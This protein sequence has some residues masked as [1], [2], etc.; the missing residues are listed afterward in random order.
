MRLIKKL[1]FC[2]VTVI[3]A[4]ALAACSGGSSAAP[5]GAPPEVS[6]I[7]IDVIPT[8]DAAGIY[9]AADDGYFTQQGLNVKIVT[10]ETGA[11]Q[12]GALQTGAAQLVQGS[13]VGFIQ[14]Q[15]AGSFDG[16]PVS[17]RFVADTAEM[18]PGNQGLFVMP[19]HFDSLDQLIKAHATVGVSENDDVGALLLD[20]L[21]SASGDKEDGIK[22]VSEPPLEL[23]ALL[24]KGTISAAYLGQPLITYVEEQVGA[25]ELTD[26]DQGPLLNLPMGAIVGS[27]PWVQSHPKTVAAFQRALTEAQQV[28]DTNRHSVEA[29]LEKWTVGLTPLVAAN[30]PAESYPLSMSASAM[31]RVA[32]AMYQYGL[33]PKPFQVSSMIQPAQG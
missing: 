4:A 1:G 3:P 28:A 5:T 20:G 18:E 33:I 2:L 23:P 22:Q 32:D 14:S 11:D 29:A 15:E 10:N 24:A 21:L 7:T 6:S 13:Y 26:L 27:T 17:M 9:I 19:G 30:I 16:K 25:V 12:V 8:S 31:Q